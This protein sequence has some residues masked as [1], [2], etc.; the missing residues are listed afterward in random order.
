MLV[1]FMINNNN[2]SDFS[3]GI[4]KRLFLSSLHAFLYI[5]KSTQ[6]LNLLFTNY[7]FDP[8]RLL[9][10][11]PSWSMFQGQGGGQQLMFHV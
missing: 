11:Q 6:L 9:N 5:K 2:K 7:T 8:I 4:Q 1:G 10:V 3:F